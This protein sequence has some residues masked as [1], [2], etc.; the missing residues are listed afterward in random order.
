VPVEDTKKYISLGVPVVPLDED[1][2]PLVH[3]LKNG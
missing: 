2:L 3:D 1:N